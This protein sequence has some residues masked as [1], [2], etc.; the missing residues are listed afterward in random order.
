[1]QARRS[2]L[3]ST[4]RT[5]LEERERSDAEA[6]RSNMNVLDT[7]KAE[8][9]S[10]CKEQKAG[11][12]GTLRCLWESAVMRRRGNFTEACRGKIR[13]LVLQGVQDGRLDFFLRNRCGGDVDKLC[14]V[15]RT[16]V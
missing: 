15:E 2:Q 10:Y 5:A 1:M 12:L 4:C 9:T 8:A 7:C 13:A 14:A 6:A 16:R 3:S 11:E